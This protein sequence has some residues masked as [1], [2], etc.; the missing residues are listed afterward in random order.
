MPTMLNKRALELVEAVL[1]RV[2]DLRGTV[3]ETDNGGRVVDLGTKVEG[4]LEAGRLLAEVCLAGLGE[5]RIVPGDVGGIAW[6]QVQVVTDSP[7]EACLLSQYAGWQLS[8]GK[9]FAMGSGPMRAAAAREELFEK[10][11]YHESAGS[12]VG[13]L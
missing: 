10:L 8:V 9:F 12:A 13:V 1:P 7:V 3:L 6:P 5:V 2:G 11:G 4:S